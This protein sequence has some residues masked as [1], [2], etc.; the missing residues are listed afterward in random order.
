MTDIGFADLA[1][2]MSAEEKA[3]VKQKYGPFP[4]PSDE[5]GQ[6]LRKIAL[7]GQAVRLK[8]VINGLIHA[9]DELSD[10]KSNHK[11]GRKVWI[12]IA[13]LVIVTF[14]IIA[15]GKQLGILE[16]VLAIA[17]ILGALRDIVLWLLNL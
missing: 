8:R 3:A 1:R 4:N 10:L 7:I 13:I 9:C 14:L 5:K 16:W 2:N 11:R 15:F 6:R 12:R 17:R